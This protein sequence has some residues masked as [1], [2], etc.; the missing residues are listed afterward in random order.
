MA[1]DIPQENSS[2]RKSGMPGLFFSVNPLHMDIFQN[3]KECVVL[4]E[5]SSHY[6]GF[7][8]MLAETS[9]AKFHIELHA[10]SQD[11]TDGMCVNGFVR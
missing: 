6:I 7:T 3:K 1:G 10:H 8:C 5:L 11:I 2:I 9:H 4:F